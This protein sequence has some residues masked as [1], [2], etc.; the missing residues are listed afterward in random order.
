MKMN[1]IYTETSVGEIIDKITILEIKK[2]KISKKS[3]LS[4]INKE[5]LDLINSIKKNVK[6]NKK[7]KKLWDELKKTNLKIWEMENHKRLAQKEL[8][9]L[10]K[11][12]RDV[13]KYNDMRAEIKLK[14]N[15]FTGSNLREIKQY[16]KY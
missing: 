1:K 7:F 11:V 8:E 10:T 14:I 12:A 16:T 4:Q 15:K 5:Y 13:Y 9:K 6:I 3:N 2:K